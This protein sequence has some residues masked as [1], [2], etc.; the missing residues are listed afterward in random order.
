MSLSDIMSGSGLH[1][2]A[3]IGLVL[4]LLLFA[5]VLVYTFARRNRDTFERARH[6]PLDDAPAAPP[7]A[8]ENRHDAA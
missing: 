1:L 7:S 8:P 4:F 6:A 3:E 5:G 2:F